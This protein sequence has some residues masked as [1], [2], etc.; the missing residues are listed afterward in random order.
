MEKEKQY[1]KM[2]EFLVSKINKMNLNRNE[3]IEKL[4]KVLKLKKWRKT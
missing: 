1:E 4:S 2:K 3:E